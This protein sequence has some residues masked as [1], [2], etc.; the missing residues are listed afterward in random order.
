MEHGGPAHR[1][2]PL[3]QPAALVD[4]GVDA[5]GEGEVGRHRHDP[6]EQPGQL[7]LATVSRNRASRSPKWW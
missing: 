2:E 6:G 1:G 7:A 4:E 5:F 3:E